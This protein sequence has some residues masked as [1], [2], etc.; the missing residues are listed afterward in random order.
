MMSI[1]AW[2]GLILGSVFSLVDAILTAMI[3]DEGGK[4]KNVLLRF[5]IGRFGTTLGLGVPKLISM[6]VVGYI[7]MTYPEWWFLGPIYLGIFAYISWRNFNL[8][9]VLT[10][11]R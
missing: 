7:I 1:I 5:L 2:V 3:L 11:E 4:E 6:V 9:R 10:I 8:L